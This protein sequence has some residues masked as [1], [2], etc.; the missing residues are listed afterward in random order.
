LKPLLLKSAKDSDSTSRVINLSSAGHRAGGIQ[1]DNLNPPESAYNKWIAY[2]Q[3]KTANIYMT[4]AITRYYGE[5]G[6]TGLAV[7]P[8][9]VESELFRHMV[10]EDFASLDDPAAMQK[11]M[12]STKQGAA[13]SVWAAISSRFEDV[14]NGGRLLG[15]VGESRAEQDGD[16]FDA[17]SYAPHAYDEEAE[18][19]LWKVSCEAVGLPF[20]I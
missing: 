8:G 12:K 14:S 4:N 19:K 7:H 10:P 5:Q 13:T 16:S 1:F 11:I 18:D 2:A 17:A 20:D 3:A 15:D 6:I 9:V